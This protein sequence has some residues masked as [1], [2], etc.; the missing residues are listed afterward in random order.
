MKLIY[1]ETK[2]ENYDKPYRKVEVFYSGD[3]EP[4]DLPAMVRLETGHG[5]D[6]ID[7]IK[8]YTL[9]PKDWHDLPLSESQAIRTAIKIMDDGAPGPPAGPG[10]IHLMLQDMRNAESQI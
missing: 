1:H 4:Y 8:W 5:G 10:G 3:G 6:Q 9:Q 7:D 2:R